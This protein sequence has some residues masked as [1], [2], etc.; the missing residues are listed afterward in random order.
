MSPWQWM[1]ALALGLIL[2]AMLWLVIVTGAWIAIAILDRFAM[3]RKLQR[4]R[5]PLGDPRR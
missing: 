4:L 3:R 5:R 1:F 2:S